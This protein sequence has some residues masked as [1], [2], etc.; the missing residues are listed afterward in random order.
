[1]NRERAKQILLLHRPGDVGDEDP[2]MAEAFALL[3]RDAELQRWFE[4]QRAVQAAVRRAFRTISPPAAFKEQIISERPWHTRPVRPR[5]LMVATAAALALFA[6]VLWWP[7]PQPRE[8][9]SFAGY[10][11][12]MVGTA[13]R[14]YGMELETNNL[15]SI[16]VFLKAHGA[17]SDFVAPSGLS[18]A[19]GTGCLTIPWRGSQVSMICFRTGQPLPPGQDSDL[20]FFIIDHA[21]VPD[22]PATEVPQM[23]IV[24]KVATASW[25]WEGKA[26]VL[27]VDGDEALLKEFLGAVR[28]PA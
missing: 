15:E 20:W 23:A 1:M 16:R 9:R 12:R 22:A 11:S 25:T 4:G 13:Q 28:P 10:R 24:K 7:T 21:I 6:L 2:E 18:R 8:D 27:A 14:A 5:H 17:P 26:Y 3:G 19:T